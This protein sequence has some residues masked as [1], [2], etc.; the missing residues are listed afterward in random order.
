[1]WIVLFIHF[2]NHSSYHSSNWRIE[3]YPKIS[4]FSGST[5]LYS[6][7]VIVTFI[8]TTICS[9]CCIWL[10]TN[11]AIFLQRT[12]YRTLFT[13]SIVFAEYTWRD[14]SS[15]NPLS[16]S[17]IERL[18]RSL[19]TPDVLFSLHWQWGANDSV[20]GGC[21]LSYWVTSHHNGFSYLTEPSTSA[22]WTTTVHVIRS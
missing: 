16:S 5:K 18:C 11:S 14:H 3:S 20:P 19:T 15:M 8:L 4:L 7:L 2:S 10:V 12:N 17:A 9:L 22:Y 13:P 21:T 6:L 1:M